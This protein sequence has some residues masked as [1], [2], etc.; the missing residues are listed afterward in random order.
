MILEV[1]HVLPFQYIQVQIIFSV[2]LTL[3]APS[4]FC[5]KHSYS[6]LC[7]LRTQT[8]PSAN[9]PGATLAVAQLSSFH[10]PNTHLASKACM[11]STRNIPH[12][13]PFSIPFSL[14]N[15]QLNWSKCP[16]T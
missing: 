13:V 2:S 1:M 7:S 8:C 16:L 10:L 9:L 14:A 5:L 4:S 6:C 3:P 15:G 11:F 12:N